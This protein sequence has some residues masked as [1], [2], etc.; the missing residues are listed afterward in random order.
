MGG[1]NTKD[2]TI[3]GGFEMGYLVMPGARNAYFLLQDTFI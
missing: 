2:K 1:V 3:F